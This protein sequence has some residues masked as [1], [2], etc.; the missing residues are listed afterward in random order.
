[1][2]RYL[3]VMRCE[4]Q[5]QNTQ[6][7]IDGV[8]QEESQPDESCAIQTSVKPV[9]REGS[10][11]EGDVSEMDERAYRCVEGSLLTRSCRIDP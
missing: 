6:E 1:M 4:E 2:E 3:V 9:E 7:H 5:S 10:V 11:Q 8:R